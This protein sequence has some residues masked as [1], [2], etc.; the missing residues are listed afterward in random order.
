MKYAR[1]IDSQGVIS[2][3]KLVDGSGIQREDNTDR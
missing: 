1:K 2:S 3:E